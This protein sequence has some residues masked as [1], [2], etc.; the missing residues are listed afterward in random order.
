M[1]QLM[2]FTLL[3]GRTVRIKRSSATAW[4]G[5]MTTLRFVSLPAN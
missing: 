5:S 1:A 4:T 3:R 2:E